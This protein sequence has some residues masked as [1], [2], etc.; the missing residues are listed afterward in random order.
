[1]SDAGSTI[2]FFPEGAFGPTNNCVGIGDVLRA[3]GHRVI[4]IVEESFAGTLEAQGFEERLMRLTPPPEAEEVPGQFWKDFIRDTAPVFRRPTIEQL[5]GFIAPTFQA[6]VDG[7]K[8][9]D[10]HLLEIF[11]ELRPDA[12]VEDN[13]VSFPALFASGR[14]WVRIASCNPAEIKDPDV[15]PV[16]SGLPLGDRGGWDQYWAAYREAHSVLHADF[17]CFCQEHGAPPLPRD[18]FIHESPWL[19]LY[20]YPQEID[21]PRAR[22]VGPHWHNLQASVRATDAAW[23]LPELLAGGEGPL[24]YLSLGSLGSAD[25]ELMRSLI[26]SLSGERYRVIVSKGPQADELDL[27]PNMVGA[28]F[29]PQTSILPQVDLVITHGGNNTVTESLYF[30]KPMV[31]LPLFWDQY[32]NAQRLQ[33]TGLGTRLDTYGHSPEELTGAIDR[34]LGG[35]ELAQRLAAMS[36]TLQAA[37][38]TERAA[39]LIEQVAAGS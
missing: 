2:V 14:P 11:E 18:D 3:R 38:G 23:E 32:D 33:E 15:P 24:L 13:V 16:F 21:Y 26:A 34:L 39:D 20:L 6:L 5:A 27:A 10:G 36:Q 30:G 28:E 29:L 4:F 12:I 31:V 1:M 37:R 17:D 19:N 9:V 25:V 35:R 22:P 8:Y 7:A